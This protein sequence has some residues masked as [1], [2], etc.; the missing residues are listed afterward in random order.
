[1]KCARKSNSHRNKEKVKRK[2]N[3]YKQNEKEK[4]WT[5]YL[6]VILYRIRNSLCVIIIVDFV[7]D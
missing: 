3:M 7:F 4:V 6:F 5:F 1:M 2:K